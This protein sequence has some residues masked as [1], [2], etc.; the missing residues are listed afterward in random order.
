MLE[1]IVIINISIFIH[2]E[3]SLN[4]DYVVQSCV[5]WKMK[6]SWEFSYVQIFILQ[7]STVWNYSWNYFNCGL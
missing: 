6:V 1:K 5:K 4:P 2:L 7:I 3:R